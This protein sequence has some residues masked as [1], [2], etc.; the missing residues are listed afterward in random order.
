M[1]C[2]DRI[3]NLI[4]KGYNEHEVSYEDK[5]DAGKIARAYRKMGY[6]AQVVNCNGEYKVFVKR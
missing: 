2:E 6:N 1:A 5:E 3:N 4:K